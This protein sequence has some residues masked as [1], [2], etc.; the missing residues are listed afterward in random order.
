VLFAQALISTVAHEN[1][2]HRPLAS[3]AVRLI[4]EFVLEKPAAGGP[5]AY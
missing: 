3:E 2:C 5:K 4:Q 1:G